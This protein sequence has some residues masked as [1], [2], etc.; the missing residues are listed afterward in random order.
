M[1]CNYVRAQSRCDA[2]YVFIKM[3]QF[4]P[5]NIGK[6]TSLIIGAFLLT[7]KVVVMSSPVDQLLVLK[8]FWI[9]LL[10]GSLYLK[11]RKYDNENL[12][13]KML[14]SVVLFITSELTQ[15][16][17]KDSTSNDTKTLTLDFSLSD[18]VT[19]ILALVFL[20]CCEVF[21]RAYYL[22]KNAIYTS[23]KAVNRLAGV[24]FD[25]ASQSDNCC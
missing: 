11:L 14:C 23:Q 1:L 9:A 19:F 10:I 15:Y 8:A 2:F 16:E 6:I 5:Q 24:I 3:S 17:A 12:P 7:N 21:S 20:S 25:D 22:R 13:P 18:L 4:I